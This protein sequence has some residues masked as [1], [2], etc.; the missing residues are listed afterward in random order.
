MR[1]QDTRAVIAFTVAA[2]TACLP[3]ASACDSYVFSPVIHIPTHIN[4]SCLGFTPSCH[5]DDDDNDNDNGISQQ[6]VTAIVV[7]CG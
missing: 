4:G 2:L 3:V 5:D 7:T 6:T 1:Q